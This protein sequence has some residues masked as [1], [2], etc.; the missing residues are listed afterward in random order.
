MNEGR[1]DMDKKEVLAYVVKHKNLD[2]RLASRSGGIFTAVSDYILSK[3][4]IIYGCALNEEFMA[5]HKR[6]DSPAERDEFRGSKYIQSRMGNIFEQVK[7]DLQESKYVLF[8]GTSCQ[9]EGL[10]KYLDVSSDRSKLILMDI[11]CHGV[12]SPR[13]WKDYLEYVNRKHPGK[14]ESVNF[15]NKLKYGWGDHVETVT[16]DGV[17]YD[18]KTYTRFFYDHNI[19]RPS[20]YQCPFKNVNHS[21]DITIADCWGIDEN[22]PEFTDNKGVSLVLVNTQTG[23]D[24]FSAVTSDIEFVQCDIN[25]YLQPPLQHPYEKPKDREQFWKYY[26]THKFESSIRRTLIMKVKRR[27]DKYL[28]RIKHER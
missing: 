8:T 6:A 1:K 5:I 17:D 26:Y 14:I 11:V 23:K 20:C 13:V 9:T 21:S 12:P 27:I 18:S 16:I 24:I 19:L 2:I 10:M 7:K 4:G 15:R 28:E 25:D 3:N 22:M